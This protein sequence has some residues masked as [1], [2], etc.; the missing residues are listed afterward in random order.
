MKNENKIKL[1]HALV[2]LQ[3]MTN[4]ATDGV[5]DN[6]HTKLFDLHNDTYFENNENMNDNEFQILMKMFDLFEI[7][8]DNR[9]SRK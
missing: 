8:I 1:T 2:Q 4:N 5:I 3:Q 6:V 7:M 9:N